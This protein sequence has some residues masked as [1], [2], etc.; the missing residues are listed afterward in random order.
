MDKIIDE[1]NEYCDGLTAQSIKIFHWWD[2]RLQSEN[3]G[4]SEYQ[5][6]E[7][8]DGCLL[9]IYRLKISDP[10]GVEF[11]LTGEKFPPEFYLEMCRWLC[12]M[13]IEI[14]HLRSW[15]WNLPEPDMV[16]GSEQEFRRERLIKDHVACGLPSPLTGSLPASKGEAFIDMR[17]AYNWQGEAENFNKRTSTLWHTKEVRKLTDREKAVAWDAGCGTASPNVVPWTMSARMYGMEIKVVVQC[18]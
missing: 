13:R 9:R 11:S 10:S 8:S 15:G 12:D 1:I 5:D 4:N 3:F 17:N 2:K 6:F 18:D 14:I 7:V 16:V